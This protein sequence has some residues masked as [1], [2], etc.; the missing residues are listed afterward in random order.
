MLSF[1][2]LFKQRLFRFTL[3]FFGFVRKIPILALLAK[4]TSEKIQSF[5]GVLFHQKVK[6]KT[7]FEQKQ[8]F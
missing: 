8:N 2:G 3:L 1:V 7:G 4:C 5:T 6:V